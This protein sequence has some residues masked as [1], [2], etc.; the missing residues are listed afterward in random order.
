MFSV[1][2][3]AK[4]D[5]NSGNHI[6][7]FPSSYWIIRGKLIAGNYPSAVDLE[8]RKVKLQGFETPE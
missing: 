2:L 3:I 1:S 8:E 4:N 5:M 6:L 7:P